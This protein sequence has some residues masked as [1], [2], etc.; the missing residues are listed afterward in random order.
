[1]FRRVTFRMPDRDAEQ[2]LVFNARCGH[3]VVSMGNVGLEQSTLEWLGMGDGQP[4]S[5]GDQARV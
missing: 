1:M 3:H 5:G 2:V 4:S